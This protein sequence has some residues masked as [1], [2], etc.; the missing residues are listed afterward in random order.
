MYTKLLCPGSR[1]LIFSNSSSSLMAMRSRKADPWVYAS[2]QIHRDLQQLNYDVKI[3]WIPFHVGVSSYKVA[4]GLT[5]QAVESTND[6]MILA[7]RAMVGQWQNGWRT[8]DTGRFAHSIR[9]VVSVKPWFDGQA[10]KS[11]V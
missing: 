4:D 11:S 5:R 1:Y 2:K 10:E 9:H 3:I 6:H 8:G 7:R